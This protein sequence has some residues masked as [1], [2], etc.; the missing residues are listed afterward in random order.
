MATDQHRYYT[1]AGAAQLLHVSPSTV[2]RWIA[3]GRLPAL[4][5][6]PKTIR[7]AQEDL[8]A[9]EQP[10]RRVPKE[11]PTSLEQLRAK[12]MTPPSAEELARRRAVVA[13]IKAARGERSIA[14]LTAADLVHQARQEEEESYGLDR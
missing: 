4:R 7:I 8:R 12:L 11:E 3:A 1:V 2:W 5:L 10:A 9:L 14:P 13:R 6:G